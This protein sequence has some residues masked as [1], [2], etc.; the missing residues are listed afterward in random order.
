MAQSEVCVPFGHTW[1]L[2]VSADAVYLLA[3]HAWQLR[4]VLVLL[5]F[6]GGQSSQATEALLG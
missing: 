4:D 2:D 1:Q 5:N 3:G 6:P